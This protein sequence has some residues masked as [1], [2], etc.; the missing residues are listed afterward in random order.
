[1]EAVKIT[2]VF[3]IA[4]WQNK[5]VTVF[6]LGRSGRAAADLLLDVGAL[7]TIV[8]EHTSH[9]FESTSAAYGLQGVRVFRGDE[10]ADG[11]RDL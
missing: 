4:S 1:M 7:V 11:L 10:V 2:P 9:D 6:G 5:R 8:E 3:P